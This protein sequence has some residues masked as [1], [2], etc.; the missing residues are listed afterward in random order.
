MY[1]HYEF[2]RAG[3]VFLSR[4]KDR[5]IMLPPY[6]KDSYLKGEN[7]KDFEDKYDEL[8]DD[9]FEASPIHKK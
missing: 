6:L 3:K 1:N 9:S 2:K 8:L 7:E 4:L 5:G